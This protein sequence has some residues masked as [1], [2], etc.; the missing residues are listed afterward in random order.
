M[1]WIQARIA[2]MLLIPG[3][4][5]ARAGADDLDLYLRDQMARRHIPGL[6]LAV[7]R[8]GKVALARGYGLASVELAVPATPSTVFELA[9]VSKQFTATAIMLLVED[10]KL[11]LDDRIVDRLPGLPPLWAGITV[12]HLLNH[13]SGIPDYLRPPLSLR[14]DHSGGDLIALV[15][16]KPLE[17]PPGEGWAY[18]NTNYLLLGLIVERASGQAFPRFLDD[19]IFRPLGM[20]AT[21]V[22]DPLAIIPG[23]ATGYEHAGGTLRVRD[24]L[25]PTLSATGDGGVSSSALDLARWSAALDGETLLRAPALRQMWTPG[26]LKDGTPTHYGFGWA[27]GR[28]GDHPVIEHSGAFPG[29]NAHLARYPD[30]KLT[31][32]VL[33]NTSTARAERIARAIAARFI[34]G[35]PIPAEPAEDLEDPPTTARHK[36]LLLAWLEGKLDPALFTPEARAALFPAAIE[37]VR[38]NLAPLGPLRTFAWLAND[39]ERGL[40]TRRYRAELGQTAWALTITLADDGKIAGVIIRPE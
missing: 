20:A 27:I 36:A 2:A 25:S 7:V 21:R 29:F 24:F 23:R 16:G 13:T 4:S 40:R 12:R 14:D 38:K 8:E 3:L 33:A 34:P 15:A 18:S 19:R 1:T 10:G 6:S 32:I 37:A 35:L 17:F 9:S 11:G 31:V 39:E 5:P 22:T 30:D 26:K 28:D